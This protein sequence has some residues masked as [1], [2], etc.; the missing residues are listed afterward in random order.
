MSMPVPY[1]DRAPRRGPLPGR[2]CWV[3]GKNGGL[4]FT[5]ALKLAGYRME[6]GTVAHAHNQCMAKAQREASKHYKTK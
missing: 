4:G 6:P 5:T 2:C 1:R 3:C